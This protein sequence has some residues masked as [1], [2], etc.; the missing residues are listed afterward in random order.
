M[1]DFPFNDPRIISMPAYWSENDFQIR[2]LETWT[3]N[4]FYYGLIFTRI[5]THRMQWNT[6][7]YIILYEMLRNVE[8]FIRVK[9]I[10]NATYKRLFS[11]IVPMLA[12]NKYNSISNI[13]PWII[14]Q[15]SIFPIIAKLIFP[16]MIQVSWKRLKFHSAIHCHLSN[17]ER[18]RN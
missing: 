16:E 1:L 18:R 11:V 8:N 6:I 13:L 3:L 9:F 2:K 17:N 10:I 14:I 7:L 4:S 5:F 12:W 15:V